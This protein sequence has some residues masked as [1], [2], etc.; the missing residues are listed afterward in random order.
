MYKFLLFALLLCPAMLQAQNNFRAIVKQADGTPLSGASAALK[1]GSQ[2]SVADSSGMLELRNIPN[3]KQVIVFSFLGFEERAGTFDFPA[4]SGI[5]HTII[6]TPAAAAEDDENNVVITS[7]RSSRSIQNIPTRVEFIAGEELEEKANMKPGDIRMLLSES[8][9]IQVQQTS[10]TSANASIRI[11]GLDG[12]YTQILKDGFPLY[13]GYSGGLGLLQTPPLDLKQAEFIKGSASTLYGGGAIAGIVNLISKT[14]T[15]ERE[16]RFFI[17][18]TSARGLDLNGFYGQRFGKIGTTIYAASNSNA[19]YDPAGIDLSAI[20]KFERFTFNPRLF[21]YPNKNTTINIGL[22]TVFE[23]RIGGDMHFIDGDDEAGHTYFERNKT[24]R[25]ST[26]LALDHNFGKCSHLTFKNS[27]NQFTRRIELPGYVFDGKQ[28]SSFSELAFARHSDKLEWT[29]GVNFYTDN[30]KE[31]QLTATPLRNYEQVTFGAFV[32]NTWNTAK[33]LNIETGLRADHVLDYGWVVLPRLSALFKITPKLTS[34]LGGGLGYKAP[35][36][37]TE[38]SERLQYKDVMP[39]SPQNNSLEKSYGLNWDVNYR[40]SFGP[41]SFSINQ[42]LFYTRLS[43]PLLLQPGTQMYFFRN[44]AGHI[45]SRGTET[46]IKL[47]Y[48]DFKLFLGYTFTDAS[49]HSG[50]ARTAAPLT[51]KHRINAVLMYEVDEKW[52]L[53]LESYYFS[54]QRLTDGSTGRDYTILGFM[55][56]RIW[57]KFSLMINFENFLDARQ[58]RFGSVY[59]GTI[60]SPV[61]KDIYAPMDGFVVNGGV[62]LRL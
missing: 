23:N 2:G 3:G 26:Q 14:P 57:E 11:Q 45:D 20:P 50:E 1:N 5:V 49:L 54:K 48:S 43:K 25:I 4:A 31:Q 28:L 34:R 32:Q 36:I 19:S 24:K 33:W 39:V 21:I 59:N 12:R 7:T 29:G 17:N 38:E 60:T 46:N 62:K 61:F 13:S 55:A 52:K 47:G 40:T 44:D 27:I 42:L 16:L 37:F 53:G 22:N 51:P 41:V 56:E 30:F 9:G 35:T 18:G 8:T 10:A 58:S 15:P 6:L